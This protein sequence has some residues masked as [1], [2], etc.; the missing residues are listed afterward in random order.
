MILQ[1]Q[2]WPG[3]GHPGIHCNGLWLEE[4]LLIK[5][6]P[7]HAHASIIK[8]FISELNEIFIDLAKTFENVYHIDARGTALSQDDWWDEL[9]LKPHKF[10][11]VAMAYDYCINENSE[12]KKVINVRE[13]IDGKI[14]YEWPC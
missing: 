9:H 12:N 13:I 3:V 7:K 10:K 5:G 6:I 8:H 1:F 2:A 14:K 4:P 11:Q